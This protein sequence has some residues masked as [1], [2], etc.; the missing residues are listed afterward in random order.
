MDRHHKYWPTGVEGLGE[1]RLRL[2]VFMYGLDDIEY[3]VLIWRIVDVPILIVQS[4]QRR[5][6]GPTERLQLVHETASKDGAFEPG[7][8][9][10]IFL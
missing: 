7:D 6:D 4:S 5:H 1:Q 10:P 2:V 3:I 8:I 9:V